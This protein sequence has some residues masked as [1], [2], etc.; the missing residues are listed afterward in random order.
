VKFEATQRAN[1]WLNERVFS[2]RGNVRSSERIAQA[3]REKNQLLQAGAGGL[4]VEQ[5]LVQ[6]NSQLI[7]AK[8]DLARAQS[9]QQQIESLTENGVTNTSSVSEVLQSPLIQRLKEQESEVLRN[10]AELGTRYGPKH[11]NMINVQAELLDVESKI[12]LE[13]DRVVAGIAGE[14]QIAA[15]RVTTLAENLETLKAENFQTSRAQV[16]LREL[17]REVDANSLLLETFLTRFK[18]T[19][20]QSGLTQDDARII[21]RADI[22]TAASFPKKKLTML[23]VIF[24]GL[25]IGVGLVFLLEALDNG[26]R[27]FDQL[28]TDLR[29]RGLGMIPLVDKAVLKKMRPEEYLQDRP[30]SSFAEAH[31]NIHAAL[32]F[33]G[34]SGRAPKVLAVTSSVPGE[35]KS[36]ASLC[37]AQILGRSGQK[38]LVVE[39]DLRRPVLKHRLNIGKEFASLNDLFAS[40]TAEKPEPKIYEDPI[41]GVHILWGKSHDDPQ[42]LFMSEGF[43]AFMK[44][45][46]ERYDLIIID[47]PPVMAVSDVLV[48]SRLADAL[49]FAVQWDKTTRGIV[50]SAILQLEQTG[51]P[52]AGAILTQVNMKRHQGY[53]Y[54]DQGYYYGAKGGYYTN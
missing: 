47:T 51:I 30:T 19:T 53:G 23:L 33:T 8:V 32:M 49:M 50:K 3:Y 43:S 38:I 13:A 41:S 17:E 31:R 21:S 16:Q 26:Y 6:L 10:R 11:P 46:R 42:A 44:E 18:E 54:E 5:Q 48:V 20:S 7:D 35:G 28:R 15:I 4:V 37:L 39:A 2:L 1:E 29:L 52:I 34:T 24:A 27:N 36:T 40:S 14:A 25:G 9:R 22:P 12:K 45:V